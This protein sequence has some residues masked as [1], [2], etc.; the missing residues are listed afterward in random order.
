MVRIDSQDTRDSNY[1]P[2]RPATYDSVATSVS[3]EFYIATAGTAAPSPRAYLRFTLHH[4]R[5]CGVVGR[6]EATK[7]TNGTLT[8][9]IGLS[10][11]D[12]FFD[13]CILYL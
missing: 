4:G 8:E 13:F 5:T 12:D 11:V 6:K 7:Q 10:L 3:H 2:V 9:S 1:V